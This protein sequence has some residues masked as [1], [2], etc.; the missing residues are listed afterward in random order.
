MVKRFIFKHTQTHSFRMTRFLCSFYLSEDIY[1]CEH[2][3][4]FLFLSIV[5]A[6]GWLS[7]PGAALN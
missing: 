4:E 3:C 2:F 7:V 1:S 6:R 5:S